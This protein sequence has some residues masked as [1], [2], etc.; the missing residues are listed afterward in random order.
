MEPEIGPVR[1]DPDS[2]AWLVTRHADCVSVLRDQ[3]FSA[4][5]GQHR[6]RRPDRLPVSM[7][8]TDPP[9]HRRLRS[10][11]A[12]LVSQD[13]LR[14]CQEAVRPVAQHFAERAVSRR[15]VDVLPGY[16]APVA[17]VALATVLGVPSAELVPFARLSSAAAVN[18][19][20]LAEGPAVERGRDAGA[21][22]VEYLRSLIADGRIEADGG[23]AALIQSV[24]EVDQVLATLALVIVGGF[25]PLVHLIGNGL[26]A[27]LRRP[28]QLARLRA[29]PA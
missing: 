22:L 26:D 8:N 27:L 11:A 14:R 12:T 25:E 1:F 21:E 7:L 20:P 23:I 3:R 4:A 10:P 13:R 16:A 29:G 9:E 6:R 28:D 5:L 18:L 17:A 15:E 2:R 19:D 24:T